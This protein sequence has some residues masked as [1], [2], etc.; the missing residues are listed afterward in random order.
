MKLTRPAR[1]QTPETIIAL[2][3]V[4][5]FLLVFFMVSN[6]YRIAVMLGIVVFIADQYFGLGLIVGMALFYN[7]ILSPVVKVMKPLANPHFTRKNRKPPSLMGLFAAIVLAVLCAAKVT[8][9]T[10]RLWC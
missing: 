6:I 2:I 1:R 8:T 4:V 7:A 10:T 5:F 9:A 3:D